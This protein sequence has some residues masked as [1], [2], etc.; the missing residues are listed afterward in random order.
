MTAWTRENWQELGKL[1]D[2]TNVRGWGKGD[3]A[4]AM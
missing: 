1:G 2:V 4:E 3:S